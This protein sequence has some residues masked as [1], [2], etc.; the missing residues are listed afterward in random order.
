[1]Q[2]RKMENNKL[3]F[4]AYKSQNGNTDFFKFYITIS[5]G[6]FGLSQNDDGKK[7]SKIISIKVMMHRN[8]K[9]KLK[10]IL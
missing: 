2:S 5:I 6:R 1:M 8:E 7:L 10:N 9:K 4:L 3:L